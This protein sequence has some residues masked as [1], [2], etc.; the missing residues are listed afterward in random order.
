M[1]ANKNADH[2][3]VDR[4]KVALG[5]IKNAPSAPVSDGKPMVKNDIEDQEPLELCI[6]SSKPVDYFEAWVEREALSDAEVDQWVKMLNIARTMNPYEESAPPMAQ[7]DEDIYEMEQRWNEIRESKF[8]FVSFSMHMSVSIRYEF[9]LIS[10]QISE[11]EE[12]EMAREWLRVIP[13]NPYD[14]SDS[15]SSVEDDYKENEAPMVNVYNDSE[16]YALNQSVFDLSF[17]SDDDY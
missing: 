9:F 6:A 14:D 8:N 12:E 1:R 17:G 11:K 13:L 4:K 7:L 15:D 2:S 10:I 3:D 16:I 5:D